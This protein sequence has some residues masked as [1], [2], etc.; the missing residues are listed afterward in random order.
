MKNL[1]TF[2][3]F[4][5][6]NLNEGKIGDKLSAKFTKET[7]I[8]LDDEIKDSNLDGKW[9]VTRLWAPKDTGGMNPGLHMEITQKNS[10]AH[11]MVMDDKGKISDS[12]KRIKKL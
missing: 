11:W 8:G 6:E 1:N 10:T 2:E 9:T 12:M 5:N 3:E 4:V 7:G